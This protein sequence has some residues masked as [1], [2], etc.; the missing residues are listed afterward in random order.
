M[1]DYLTEEDKTK[2]EKKAAKK[3]ETKEVISE[4]KEVVEA[5]VVA[6]EP[7]EAIK[8]ETVDLSKLTV[9][10]L[11]AMAKDANIEGYT[12]LKKAELVASLTK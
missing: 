9:A 12:T 2:N 4:V 7:K 11:K 8:E 1:V 3:E 6:S 10:E 5:P